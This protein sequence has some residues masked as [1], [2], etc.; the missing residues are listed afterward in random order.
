MRWPVV[1][2]DGQLR[3]FVRRIAP[4]ERQAHD[5]VHGA[6]AFAQF[7][8][9]LAA[10]ERGELFVQVR[11]AR[12]RRRRRGRGRPRCGAAGCSI[13]GRAWRPRSRGW[14]SRR[15]AP[16]CRAGAACRGPGR[17]SLI[18]TGADTPLSMWP[19]RSASGPPTAAKMPGTDAHALGELVEDFLARLRCAVRRPF[20]F[21][22]IDVEL[23]R[24]NRHDVIAAFG[25]A[26]AAA[27]F[28]HFRHG[29]DLLLD[30][31]GDLVHLL[32]RSAGRGG[33]GDER[34]LFLEGR[35]EV[36][37]H[38]RIERER[39]DDDHAARARAADTAGSGRSAAACFRAAISC[40]ARATPSLCSRAG[41]GIEQER[42]EHRNRGERDDERGD[43][44]K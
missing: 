10:D 42:A 2:F 23:R 18:A 15:S 33:G 30:H 31:I 7:G 44:A 24:G 38:L 1:G 26:E 29:E 36:L 12:C 13:A 28:A 21:A 3:D 27:D 25:A 11:R 35:Q 37:A 8:D 41:L 32:Q 22:K 39:A 5:E 6:L 16:R 20:G 43:H 34:G 17:R 4:L 14:F 40:R 9:F 19:M